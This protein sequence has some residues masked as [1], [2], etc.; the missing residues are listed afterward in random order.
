MQR[1]DDD[2]ND[3]L[4]RILAERE[5]AFNE[6]RNPVMSTQPDT[7]VSFIQPNKSGQ[8]PNISTQPDTGVSFIQPNTVV[9]DEEEQPKDKTALYIVGGVIAIA[10]LFI[11]YNSMKKD[12]KTILADITN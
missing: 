8:L 6:K 3:E 7:S 4:A 12:K 9:E 1:F 5:K 11:L 2:R 10:G